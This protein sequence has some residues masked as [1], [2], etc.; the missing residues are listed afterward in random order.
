M[1]EVL[2]NDQSA[3]AQPVRVAPGLIRIQAELAE[4]ELPPRGQI[5]FP[6]ATNLMEFII[7]LCPDEGF[8]KNGKFQFKFSIKPLYPHDAPKVKCVTLPPVFHPNIDTE[9]NV[10][11]NILREDWNPVLSISAVVYGLLSLFIEPN[12]NDPLNQQAAELLRT[13]RAEFGRMV[14]RSMGKRGW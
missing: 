1:S 12:P 11:L 5:E 7:T 14:A 3:A 4:L 9:G 13:N 8:W 6:D 10:C 2:K